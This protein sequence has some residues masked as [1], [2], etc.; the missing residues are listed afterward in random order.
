MLG[1]DVPV[2]ALLAH[3]RADGWCHKTPP[4]A[5][6]RTSPEHIGE[7]NY[8]ARRFYLQCLVNLD[9]LLQK[10]LVSLRS[11]A[12]KSYYQQ[13]K[14]TD[15]PGNVMVASG[16]GKSSCDQRTASTHPG[17]DE[18]TDDPEPVVVSGRAR[19]RRRTVG[20]QGSGDAFAAVRQDCRGSANVGDSMMEHVLESA[21]EWVSSSR[22][23]EFPATDAP[24]SEATSTSSEAS[25]SSNDNSDSGEGVAIAAASGKL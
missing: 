17:Y 1:D 10:G 25:A 20:S 7:N 21:A 9:C 4:R 12:P 23:A 13:L 24:P 22:D 18:D 3:L 11:D 14:C 8:V 19:K 2:V 15:S 5:H 16:A 6:D